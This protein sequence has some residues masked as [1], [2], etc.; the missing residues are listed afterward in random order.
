ML[1]IRVHLDSYSH[2]SPVCIYRMLQRNRA[3][4]MFII[5]GIASAPKT[6]ET[7]DFALIEK[8]SALSI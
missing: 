1:T 6:I 2:I 8:T 4:Q 7:S 3:V 5:Y